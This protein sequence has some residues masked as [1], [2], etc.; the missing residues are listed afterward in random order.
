[1]FLVLWFGVK[2]VRYAMRDRKLL[3]RL[4]AKAVGSEDSATGVWAKHLKSRDKFDTFLNKAIEYF[5][6][7][8]MFGAVQRVTEWRAKLP[9]SWPVAKVYVELYMEEHG[10]T[11]PKACDSQL[12]MRATSESAA[13]IDIKLQRFEQVE[14]LIK[15]LKSLKA[16]VG[17]GKDG[18][19]RKRKIAHCYKCGDMT[20]MAN[21]CPVT[22]KK[23]AAKL[24]KK[25]NKERYKLETQSSSDESSSSDE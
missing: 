6:T 16:T 8:R 7:M 19:V 17:D 21:E 5:T 14:S 1:M 4:Q 20:H 10:G 22:D 2:R 11:F 18:K 25:N 9:T 15:D 24:R 12:L 23:E 3:E 13:E